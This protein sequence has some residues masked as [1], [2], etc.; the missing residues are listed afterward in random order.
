MTPSFVRRAD[1]YRDLDVV[2]ARA[3]RTNQATVGILSLLAVLT[4]FWP[5]LVAL[6]SQHPPSVV[7][8]WPAPVARGGRALLSRGPDPAGPAT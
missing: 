8:A 2:D 3:P 7:A 5:V 1:P 6:V 4:G